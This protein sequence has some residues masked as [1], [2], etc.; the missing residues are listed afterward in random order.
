MISQV[1]NGGAS[2][3]VTPEVDNSKELCTP[4]TA[5]ADP[6]ECGLADVPA[7]GDGVTSGKTDAATQAVS[8]TPPIAEGRVLALRRFISVSVMFE[9]CS[10]ASVLPQ[11]VFMGYGFH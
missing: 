5:A 1:E 10:L 8:V 9:F 3:K 4:P 6:G 7:A 2:E 11:F